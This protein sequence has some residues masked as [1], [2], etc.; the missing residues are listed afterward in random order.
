MS[1]GAELKFKWHAGAALGDF[2]QVGFREKPVD[3]EDD[4][5]IANLLNGYTGPFTEPRA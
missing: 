3:A 1:Y 2:M 5:R 4:S